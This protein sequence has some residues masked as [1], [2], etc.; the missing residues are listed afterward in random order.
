MYAIDA[1]VRA[2]GPV[3][4]HHSIVPEV[5]EA[6]ISK[7]VEQFVFAKSL[8]LPRDILSAICPVHLQG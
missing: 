3:V 8:P 2:C 4:S 1:S 6:L 7:S 5:V